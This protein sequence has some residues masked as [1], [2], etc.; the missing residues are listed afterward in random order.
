MIANLCK[1]GQWWTPRLKNYGKNA[2]SSIYASLL[3]LARLL[4]VSTTKGRLSNLICQLVMVTLGGKVVVNSRSD[5]WVVMTKGG[6]SSW[7]SGYF[8]FNFSHYIEID[9]LGF[10]PL[11][12]RLSSSSHLIYSLHVYI[13]RLCWSLCACLCGHTLIHALKLAKYPN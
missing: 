11:I 13:Y 7:F 2:S 5:S 9:G 1:F 12:S 4:V 6:K 3:P 10:N 8:F